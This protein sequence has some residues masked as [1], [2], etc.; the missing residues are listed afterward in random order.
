ML[1]D[2]LILYAEDDED[3]VFLMRRAFKDA[4][5]AYRFETVSNGNQ[6]IDY[7]SG[8]G[9]YSDRI[10][11]PLPILVL[12][13]LKMPGLSGHEVLKWIRTRP[14]TCTIPVIV[15]TSSH[16]DSDI[17]RAYILGANGYLVKPGTPAELLTMVE[18]IKNYWL[19]QNRTAVSA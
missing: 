17:R 9:A 5:I 14:E 12:L 18:G 19:T 1:N 11:W 3:D 6:A 10:K 2:K 7:L 16:Q 15:L 13:D 4:G 8:N